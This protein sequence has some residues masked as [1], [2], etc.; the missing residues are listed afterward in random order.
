MVKFF[1]IVGFMSWS[2]TVIAQQGTCYLKMTAGEPY[3]I[4]N[5]GIAPKSCTITMDQRKVQQLRVFRSSGAEMAWVVDK[6]SLETYIVSTSCLV[7]CESAKSDSTSRYHSLLENSTAAPFLLENDGLTR[8]SA[9]KNNY[10]SVD[11]CPSSKKYEKDFFN[12][13]ANVEPAKE[14]PVAIAL[15]GDWLLKHADELKEILALQ[16]NHKIK[17]AWVNHT[18]HHPY[19]PGLANHQNFLLRTD[20]KPIA[21][22]I[23]QEILMLSHGL[24][25]SIFLRYPGLISSQEI[26]TTTES[27]GLIPIGSQAWIGKTKSFAPG[28]ILLLHGNGNE[29]SGIAIFYDLVKDNKIL[30]YFWSS[31]TSWGQSRK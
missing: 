15:S 22:I 28:D 8:D 26:M 16:V 23:E 1:T 18:R 2:W 14:F 24:Q 5:Y 17:I 21:E 20:V 11:L 10:L 12:F 4:T 27:F 13:I 29:P 19:T 31:L 30:K 6:N 7:G 25:P 9:S 3:S